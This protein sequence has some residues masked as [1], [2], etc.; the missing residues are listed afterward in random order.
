MDIPKRSTKGTENDQTGKPSVMKYIGTIIILVALVLILGKP[1]PEADK[2]PLV[3]LPAV[4]ETAYAKTSE[5]APEQSKAPE[6][7]VTPPVKEKPPEK[8][9]VAST[10][11]EA[12]VKR[13]WPEHLW[14][15][16][17]IVVREESSFRHDAVGKLNPDG[18]SRDYG[19]FQINDHWHAKFFASHDW[20]DA[21]AKNGVLIG[22]LTLEARA[23]KMNGKATGLAT[24]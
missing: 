5:P 19:C 8:P 17:L 14:S 2:N 12:A 9:P 3:H 16:A 15:G 21:D 18:F 1:S 10:D 22:E 13:Q 6:A 24:S 23:E 11:C 20:K 7:V 4:T